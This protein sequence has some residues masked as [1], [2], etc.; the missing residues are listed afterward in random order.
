MNDK[1]LRVKNVAKLLDVSVST[2]WDQVKKKNLPEPY[3][4]G[5]STVWKMSELQQVIA[6]LKRTER[7]AGKSNK[8]D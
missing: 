7:R 6:N 1:L 8:I 3:K 2:V 5:S 4:F